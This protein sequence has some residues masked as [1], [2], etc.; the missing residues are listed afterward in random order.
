MPHGHCYLWE[1]QVMWLH[2]ISDT[3]ITFAYLT[4]PVTLVYIVRKRKDLPFN[5]MFA[6]FG[7]FILAC[8][9][10]H[11]FE[12]VGSWEP[13]YRLSGMIKAVTAAASIATAILL[14]KLIP[15]LLAIPSLQ[16]S[17]EANEALEKEITERQRTE[18]LLR[19]AG[20]IGRLGAWSV[21][22]P[23]YAQT[24]SD[25]VCA[26]YGTPPGTVVPVAAAMA[27]YTR[28]SNELLAR[29]FEACAR[30]GTAYDVEVQMIRPDGRRL[31]CRA[32]GEAERDAAGVICRVQ[33]A[34]Q[35]IS[36]RKNAEAALQKSEVRYRSL[37][38]HMLEGY[39]YCQLLYQ[40]GQA[41]DYIYLEVNGAFERQTG[42]QDVVGKKVSEVVPGIHDANPEQLE[43]Y[44]RVAA[45]GQPEQFETYV[46]PLDTWFA[47]SV[48]SHE[49]EHFVAVFDNITGRKKA[50]ATL[51]DSTRRLQLAT[52]VAGTGVWDWD[53][54][55]DA[56]LWDA[57]M[58]ALHGLTP[59][60]MTYDLWRSAVHP[61]DFDKQAAILQETVRTR[62]KSERQFRIRRASD[63]ALR[64]IHA[65][66]MTI[67]N[68]AGKPVRVVGVNRDITE[69]VQIEQE[70]EQAKVAAAVRE[71]EERYSFLADT[72]PLIIW[73]GR[74][75][76]G[77][78][79][80]NKA[81]FEYTGLTLA[82]TQDWGWDAV[83]HPDDLAR[84]VD[85]WMHSVKTGEPY[86][87]EYRF[88]RSSDG[89]FRWHLGR[90]LP[91]RNEQGEI[92]QW[93]GT[94]TDID[95]AKRSK[96]ALEA[97]NNELGLRVLQ[98]T[99]ELHAAKEAAEAANRAK[100]EFVANM[101]HEIRTP[102][103]GVI[104][105]TGLLLDTEL[106]P[107]QRDHA[108]TIKQSGE[109]LLTI[110]NDILDFSKM[111][112]GKLDIE[113]VDL[114]LAD[115]IRGTVELMQGQANAKSVALRSTLD[116]DVPLRLRGDGGRLRQVLLN[117]IGNALKFTGDGEVRLHVSVERQT[118]AMV[119]LRFGVTDTGIGIS[120]E[121]QASLFLPFTQADG[122]TTR[123]FGGTGL[124]LAISKQL[125]AK[126]HGHM[127]VESTPGEGSTFWFTVQLAKS[128]AA[129]SA[130]VAVAVAFS[131]SETARLD[132]KQRVAGQRILIADDN[133]VNQRVVAHQ[134]RRL[135]YA[136]DTVADGMEALE[137]LSRIPY[138]FILMDCHM[139][140]LDGYET[141]KRIR[142]NDNGHQ[143]YIIAIT[144][145]AM[146]GDKDFCI[147]AGMDG[148]VSK[149]VRAAELQA[150][151]EKRVLSP[152]PAHHILV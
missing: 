74:P 100:S 120:P 33:G 97:A 38:A 108:R 28:E 47:V 133:V 112:A 39:V 41:R 130:A 81:W 134:V 30:D 31:W 85:R 58:F 104:G 1:T 89:A 145:N 64:V 136:A 95:D 148:Y 141:T 43:I 121:A 3:L 48:Y 59:T 34:L 36:E 6:C 110:I 87:I 116:Q 82:E 69:Q 40:D 149:P 105:M 103:N 56:V 60:E 98:R 83:L 92:V 8:G 86:E 146:R 65:S 128:S 19:V 20:R 70:L 139:P 125:V 77:L 67:T 49:P 138:D 4:I 9:L 2:I 37:F 131:E 61:E 17:R 88:K 18:H 73:T 113:K 29:A 46:E 135:G 129:A 68:S 93:V 118:D 94:G 102:M 22:I 54:R 52:E 62:G 143:P 114:D 55:T 76:G 147:A 5:W 75:D 152:P 12:V 11:A 150:A 53:L 106:T 21:E 7:I 84:C 91:M 142:A 13:L 24:W 51:L 123:R 32:I 57:Q 107:E 35:D 151:L 72:V 42:L 137:A 101:S 140:E 44:S 119:T 45:S 144:A 126:M 66:E 14:V 127:G 115:V 10:S 132:A 122:S 80:Y 23:S 71:G 90:A 109:A 50:E 124:G 79:Y 96:E 63:G 78:D 26:I 117:L 25:E 99:S 16:A 27:A 111:E 15:P